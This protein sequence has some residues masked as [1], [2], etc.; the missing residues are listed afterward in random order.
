MSTPDLRARIRGCLL[1]GAVGDAL[2]APV[3]FMGL[4]EIRA[5]FGADGIRDFAPAYGRI[6]AITDDTQMTL[7][8]AEGLFLAWRR[9]WTYGFSHAPSMIHAA[10]MGWFKTQG[11]HA[12]WASGSGAE[13]LLALP[14]LHSRRAPGATCLAALGAARRY[15]DV[16]VN[17]SK[18]CGGVMRVAPCGLFTPCAP[19]PEAAFRL[20]CDA[21]ALTHGHASGILPAGHFAATIALLREGAGLAQAL[22][23]ADALLAQQDG[24]AETVAALAAARALAA[25]GRPS[26]EAL[27]RLGGGWVAEEALAIA[28][29]CALVA[30]DF[31]DGVRLAANHSGDSDSTAAMAGNLLGALWGE[32]AIPVAW[33]DA[34]ELRAEIAVLADRLAA[35]ALRELDAETAS[36]ALR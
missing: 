6:G 34:L 23:G 8:T 14:E 16:A 28:I 1:G 19:T 5:R 27:E 3:E 18:G 29:A 26:P 22:D 31:A 7:F 15:G 13:G 10:Y 9:S 35:A 21:A 36:I 30:E 24:A 4:A 25:R 17:D 12:P 33:L 20:G 32:A 2:G 11:G